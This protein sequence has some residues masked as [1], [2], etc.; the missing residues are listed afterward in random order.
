MTDNLTSAELSDLADTLVEALTAS[1]GRDAN[2]GIR[3]TVEAVHAEE[4]LMEVVIDGD[5]VSTLLPMESGAIG[6][7]PGDRAYVKLEGRE[8]YVDSFRVTD[9]TDRL[10]LLEERTEGI[11]EEVGELGPAVE[12]VVEIVDTVG[13]ALDAAKAEM[14]SVRTDLAATKAEA[15]DAAQAA[16]EAKAAADA[17]GE[18]ADA[19]LAKG[20]E[21]AADAEAAVAGVRAEVGALRETVPTKV[22]VT[23]SVDE[24]KG[25]VLQSVAAGYVDKQTGATLATKSEVTQTADAIRSEV[26][27][28]YV[29]AETGATLA[30]KSELEQ[31]ASGIRSE[32]TEVSTAADAA[33]AKATS[34][35]QTAEGISA[36]VTQTAAKADATA[37]KV[38]ELT[39]TVDGIESSVGTAQETADAAVT[40]AS[41]AQQTATAIRQEV[42]QNY[43]DKKTGATLATKSEV[44][45]TAAS[46][47][48]EVARDYVDKQTGQTLATKSELA[49]TA[50]G[51]RL[52]AEQ[53]LDKV[54]NLKVGGTNLVPFT[55]AMPVTGDYNTGFSFFS[56]GTILRDGSMVATADG[57][58]VTKP[59]SGDVMNTAFFVRLDQLGCVESGDTLTLSFDYRGTATAMGNVYIIQ[60]TSPNVNW[61]G[62][63]NLNASPDEWRHYRHTW[64]ATDANV[65]T[66]RGLLFWYTNRNGEWLEIRKRSLKLEKGNTE[67]DWSPAPYDAE[68]AYATKA[69]LEVTADAIRGEVQRDYVDK[70]TGATLASKS[71]V[72][73]TADQIRQHVGENYVDKQ[74]G[75]T[76]ATKTE[77]QQTS[78]AIKLTADSA[79]SKV[80][81]LKVGGTNLLLASANSNDRVVALREGG[82]IVKAAVPDARGGNTGVRFTM[83]AASTGWA[84]MAYRM[85]GDNI[86]LIEPSTEYTA[87]LDIKTKVATNI[88]CSMMNG[89]TTNVI[90]DY[91][92]NTLVE[93]GAWTRVALTFKT[94]AD[95]S[96]KSV[97]TYLYFTAENALKSVNELEVCNF[98]LE[99]GNLATDWSPAPEDADVKYS[100][101][102][103]LQVQTDRITGVVS[104]QAGLASRVSTVEQKSDSFTVSL[105]QTNANVSSLT[106]KVDNLK[107]GGTNLLLESDTPN[108]SAS[109]DVYQVAIYPISEELV[110]G[111]EYTVSAEVTTAGRKAIAFYVG[112]GTYGTPWQPIS[113]GRRV[114]KATFTADQNR[115]DAANSIYIYCSSTGSTQVTTAIAGTCTVHWAKL[116]KGNV[117]TDWSPAPGDTTAAIDSALDEATKAAEAAA[118][119]AQSAATNSADAIA[120]TNAAVAANTSILDSFSVDE[121]NQVLARVRVVQ[122]GGVPA[123][124]LGSTTSG[125]WA[126]LTNSQLS[127]MDASTVVAYISAMKL[128]IS[129]AQV[130]G[131]LGIGGFAWVPRSNGN[132]CLK[133]V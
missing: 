25:E 106:G 70:Q 97:N 15:A 72:E 26:E 33:M 20:D 131:Q 49:Q 91:S 133:K 111:Q 109:A 23:Q 54:D 3:A 55:E 18:A 119:M 45:Q 37:T 110:V 60:G 6:A 56:S 78:D 12:N 10:S 76:L 51:I 95:V 108:R 92:A 58:K 27:Q 52:T 101:K 93:P 116:E 68:A 31:T 57:V 8:A 71:L 74:T 48:Q 32:V 4:G 1:S 87:S 43:V 75:Q 22:E 120:Q 85:L 125:L 24:A 65:R 40:A 53:A 63:P 77:L 103:E 34:V 90:A 98:K 62:F 88:R 28:G 73:Q 14:E 130:T 21:V 46:I 39:V 5:D 124:Q 82:G 126:Q 9:A 127:F 102:A 132:L 38:T 13:P 80:D 2:R 84:Y 16:A 94:R 122:A 112:G 29:S 117:A 67:T 100:T 83:A 50:D 79:L 69:S 123:L 129:Q 113:D 47:R 118:D 114:V 105:G 61:S 19:A 44:E 42:A 96:K 30:T 66:S 7:K 41:K 35:E 99:K 17:A 64:V 89:D 36:R 128:F 107:V 115:V 86:E 104:E 121:L 11:E 59:S 81:G